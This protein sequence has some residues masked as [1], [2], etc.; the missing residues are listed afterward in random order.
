MGVG[1][2]IAGVFLR[3]MTEDLDWT[4]AEYTL[5]AS[6]ALVVG[7]LASFVVGP[8]VDRCGARPLMLI[9]AVVYAG[10]FLAL[11]RVDALWQFV[12]LTMLA[13]GIG[14][15]LVGGLV[16]NTTLSKWFVAR[17][18]W[19]IALGSSG[20]SLAGLIMPI[21]MTQV[22]DSIRLARRVRVSCSA[23]ASYRLARGFGHAPTARGLR[24]VAGRY[25]T[26]RNQ[27]KRPAKYS[28]RTASA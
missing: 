24:T 5:G 4:A 27:E 12:L 25:R 21:A 17:R 23:G 22:V 13:G 2:S 28:L 9:G 26:R 6:G 1:N 10:C 14:F 3:P 11:S 18:G 19:A 7:G 20:I 8:L 16:V 15:A